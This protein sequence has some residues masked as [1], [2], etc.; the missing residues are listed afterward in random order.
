MHKNRPMIDEIFCQL[1]KQLTENP[2][3]RIQCGWKLLVILLNYYLPSERL[4]IYLLN[5]LNE[6]SAENQRLSTSIDQ[7]LINFD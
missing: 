1:L 7:L 2:H 5:Y 4:R 6:K 3:E